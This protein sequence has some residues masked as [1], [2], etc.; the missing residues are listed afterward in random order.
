MGFQQIWMHLSVKIEISVLLGPLQPAAIAK[1][2]LSARASPTSH[3]ST[4]TTCVA[5][6]SVGVMVTPQK[7]HCTRRPPT[8]LNVCGF[9][10]VSASLACAGKRCFEGT[11]LP[12]WSV[13]LGPGAVTAAVGGV[14]TGGCDCAGVVCGT[15]AGNDHDSCGFGEYEEGRGEEA[16]AASAAESSTAEGGGPGV[17]LVR[18]LMMIEITS[19]TRPVLSCRARICM[20]PDCSGGMTPTNENRHT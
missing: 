10:C 4:A 3:V 18:C 13:V 12:D 15:K 19:R 16:L 17:S 7:S 5:Y 6:R 1:R 9:Q 11:R 2:S 14:G 20:S 8:G